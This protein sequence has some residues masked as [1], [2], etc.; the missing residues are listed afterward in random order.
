MVISVHAFPWDV[1]GDEDGFA[2]RFAAVGADTVTL[3]L[4]YH[5]TR[6]ATP[7]HQGRRLVDARYAALY[8]PVR[9]A[10][11]SGRELTPLAADWMDEPDPAAAAVEALTGRGIAVNGWIVLAHNT[12]LGLAH[13]E[14]A[15]LNCFG[16]R[17]PYALCP[18]QPQVRDY[19]AT[20]AA[21]ALRELPVAGVSLE[22]CGQL[23]VAHAG[24]HEKTDGAFS[25]MEQRVLSVCCCTGCAAGW[26]RLGLNATMV[27]SVLRAAV[28]SGGWLPDDLASAL[29]TV[30][31]QA[32]DELRAR[33]LDA[34]RQQ[35]PAATVTLH[36]HPDP[37]ATGPSPGLTDRAASEVDNI[38][39][40]CW[41]TAT[42]TAD[43]VARLAG[44]AG[45]GSRPAVDAYVT[46]LPPANEYELLEHVARLREAGASRLSLYHLG[47]ASAA[48]QPL[49]AVL[50]KEFRS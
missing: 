10:A 9:P 8:R 37:W 33:V 31:H 25:A 47:L 18:S 15:V 50:A 6:A 42:A 24:C 40:P 17:Y 39:V 20:L 46:V 36:G 38:L 32:A 45:L 49:L 27:V 21:E 30:R 13:P 34:V 19:C 5:S 3:A 26:L 22:S 7:V 41:P 28:R 44:S 23:G 12:R 4:S 2:D 14:L 16:E 43:L 35:A 29:L 1:L 11:W 48:Q